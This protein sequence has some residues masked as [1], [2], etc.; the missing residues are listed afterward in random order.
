[1]NQKRVLC[2]L[3][4]TAMFC[5]ISVSAFAITLVPFANAMFKSAS[6]TMKSS[7][8]ATFRATTDKIVNSLSVASVTLQVKSESSWNTDT[9]LTEPSTVASNTN[10]YSSTANYSSE[11]KSG[12]T[13][14][15]KANFNADGN[16][17]TK[18]SSE[19]TP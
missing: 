2:F 11:L 5:I 4:L 10:T 14:R 17:I 19:V 13:Y 3:S 15:L 9:S 1:M 8:A 16:S 18:Y 12:R 7:G 6:V